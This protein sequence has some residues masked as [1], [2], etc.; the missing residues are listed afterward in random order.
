MPHITISIS[1]PEK[2]S[3]LIHLHFE[4]NT[5]RGWPAG[6][7]NGK[8]GEILVLPGDSGGA[9]QIHAGLGKRERLTPAVARQVF[10]AIA[11]RAASFEQKAWHV[12]WTLPAEFFTPAALGLGDGAYSYR[13]FAADQNAA[14]KSPPAFVFLIAAED[15]TRLRPEAAAAVAVCEGAHFARDLANAPG[16]V[17]PPMEL[18]ARLR[19]KFRG[20][21]SVSVE[22]L[23]LEK[24]RALGMGGILAVGEGSSRSPC[25]IILRHT[26]KAVKGGGRAAKKSAPLV[27]VGKAVTFDSGG[28]SIKPAENMEE[29]KYDKAGGCAVAGALLAAARLGMRREIVGVIPAAENLPSHTA[30]RPGD[31]V[32]CYDGTAVEIINTDAEGRMILADA[33]AYAA[34]RFRPAA[35]VDLAT[36]TGACVVALGTSRA[37]LFCNDENLAGKITHAAEVCGEPI[38]S[39]PHDEPFHEQIESKIGKIKNS[40]GR[41]GGA[42]TGAAFLETF[43]PAGLPWAHLDIAGVAWNSTDTPLKPLGATGYGVALLTQLCAEFDQP[44]G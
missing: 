4:D 36:L 31:V 10:R 39:L 6:L 28:I 21:P 23:G 18:A 1:L 29:M 2:K 38:W 22:V 7:F 37:G 32:R 34:K 40:G 14:K 16:N 11:R 43:V 12:N 9:P 44:R 25:L 5:P 24:L 41:W 13:E 27:L 3:P 15:A 17:L 35:L 8:R 20:V 19:A 42:C 33:I 30:Y 26:P